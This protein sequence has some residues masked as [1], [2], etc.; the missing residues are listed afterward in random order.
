LL[1]IRG[2]GLHRILVVD[3]ELNLVLLLQAVLEG[4]PDC[5]IE[6]A[7]GG[8]EALQLFAQ[9]AFDLLITDYKMP[10]MDGL[11]L[12]AQV[13]ERYP[14]TSIILITAFADEIPDRSAFHACG[15]RILGKPVGIDRIR[16]AA[17]QALGRDSHGASHL[18][19]GA[20]CV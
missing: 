14:R 5:E 12:A 10:D 15:G 11:T 6:I 17:C 4:L 18:I 2:I 7:T 9:A 1:S 19:G 8:E 3:D 13:R 16:S 20:P